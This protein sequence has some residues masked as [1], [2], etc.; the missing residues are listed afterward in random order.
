MATL[1]QLEKA[2]VAADEAGNTED[3]EAFAAEIMK[4]R[5]NSSVPSAPTLTPEQIDARKKAFAK[6]MARQESPVLAKAADFLGGAT[7]MLR[8]GINLV[9]PRAAET[10]F[11]ESG[12]DKQSLTY[13]GGQ[14]AD[15]FAMATG[16]KA[17][18]GAKAIAPGMNPILQG[19]LGGAIGGATIGGLQSES[20]GGAAIGGG[21][22]AAIPGGV[23]LAKGLGNVVAPVFS[24]AAAERGAARELIEMAG[25]K[26]ARRLAE[27]LSLGDAMKY[28]PQ[29]TMGQVAVPLQNPKINA[30]QAHW[31]S[32]F[33]SVDEF[34]NRKLQ[35]ALEPLRIEFLG[36]QTAPQRQAAIDKA[37]QVTRAFG[38]A[39]SKGAQY[40]DDAAQQVDK[41]RR[42][43]VLGQD[44]GMQSRADA[45][46]QA[47]A[48][49]T[50]MPRVGGQSASRAVELMDVAQKQSAD[51]AQRSLVSGAS[52]RL[53]DNIIGSMESRGLKPISASDFVSSLTKVKN[54]PENAP[55]DA[56][57]LL[58]QKII[59]AVGRS[60]QA[61]GGVLDAKSLDTI[62]RTAI[63]DYIEAASKGSPSQAKKLAANEATKSFKSFIDDII[64]NAGG[65]GYK[66]YMK[67]YSTA[68]ARIEKPLERMGESD[69]MA[70]AG[71][72]EVL[73]ILNSEK[74]HGTGV[75][76]RS[77]TIAQSVARAMKGIGGRNVGRAG[78][79]LTQPENTERLGRL[80]TE[81]LNKPNWGYTRLFGGPVS[82]GFGM[83]EQER[84]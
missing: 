52:A 20:L 36:A 80:M 46:S 77:I 29:E 69:E 48:I 83:M 15:P 24:K 2:F 60:A 22:G 17:F 41:V 9:S 33:G 4:M 57:R 31:Q 75:L 82:A 6:S 63:N 19:M 26:D 61:N 71:M 70:K 67:E 13:L 81:R 76:E 23:A 39:E 21:V 53:A 50:G 59:N 11:P 35:E 32:K 79:E 8:G 68:R 49:E 73:E 38:I 66:E 56:L 3:A 55:N 42:M 62:R 27:R 45:M 1:E 14:I 64:E 18:Q 34:R 40:A 51:A 43:E 30:L 10:L 44:A 72:Q 7:S 74:V 58:S 28:S 16:L 84:K 5:G 47:G 54:L 78:A 25:E 65:K 37:N 12:V